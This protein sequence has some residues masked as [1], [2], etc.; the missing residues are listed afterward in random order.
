MA[1]NRPQP[2]RIRAIFQAP[3]A[4]EAVANVWVQ[5]DTTASPPTISLL[6]DYGE[7]LKPAI[8]WHLE[9][10]EHFEIT[11]VNGLTLTLVPLAQGEAHVN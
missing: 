5:D 4:W 3:P 6:H 9:I 8:G 7:D 1:R 2:K 10:G 11:K